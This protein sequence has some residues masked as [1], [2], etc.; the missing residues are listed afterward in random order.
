MINGEIIMEGEV[1][2][3]M[4]DATTLYLMAVDMC[5]GSLGKDEALKYLE[6][7][8]II[9]SNVTEGVV[10]GEPVIDSAKKG[11]SKL[12]ETLD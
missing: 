11:V 12:Y 9:L 3:I 4:A 5:L 2:D 8:A 1:F 7:G 6:L 10:K